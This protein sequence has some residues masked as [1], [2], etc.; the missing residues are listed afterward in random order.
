MLIVRET[1]FL[2]ADLIQ[3]KYNY[4][5]LDL[6]ISENIKIILILDKKVEI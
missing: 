6:K 4:A 2:E 5:S 1:N 3:F